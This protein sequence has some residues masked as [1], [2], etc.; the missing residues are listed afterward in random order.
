MTPHRKRSLQFYGTKCWGYC[1]CHV[2][3]RNCT[4]SIPLCGFCF[5]ESLKYSR[6]N[7]ASPLAPFR[8]LRDRQI[9]K[10]SSAQQEAASADEPKCS[11]FDV[12]SHF[13]SVWTAD[14]S[15]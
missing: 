3:W 15:F 5:G 1:R 4:S 12:R 13:W 6:F 8:V 14:V 7:I 10:V 9:I 2:Q 11:K